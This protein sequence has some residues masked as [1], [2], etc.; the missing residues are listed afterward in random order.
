MRFH[1]GLRAAACVLWL[2]GSGCSTMREIPRG[3]YAA[4]PQRDHVRVVTRDGLLYDFD[5]ATFA[6][7]SLTGFKRR[8]T[9][10]RVEEFAVLG[11]P[12]DQVAHI[13]A[14]QIDWTRTGLVGGG[15][16]LAVLV[17]AYR[18]AQNGSGGGSSGGGT[19]RPP[20][21]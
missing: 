16:L 20:P 3:S 13:A 21:G 12:L 15:V 9:E 14:R 4:L 18:A 10:S 17:A 1:R 19:V 6:A 2:T 5:Y 11:L 8:D 7:D